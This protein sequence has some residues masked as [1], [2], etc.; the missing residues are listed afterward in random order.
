MY[1]ITLI[2]T[3]HSENGKCNDNELYKILEFINPEVIFD[4]LPSQYFDMF[5]SDS[6]EI[7]CANSILLNRKIPVEPLEVKSIK[8]YKQNYNVKVLPVDID[9]TSKL[10]KYQE[11]ILF[12]FSTFFKNQDY[13][14]LD[15]EKDV[16]IANEGFHYLNSE[17][18]LNFLER[19][20]ILEKNIIESDIEKERLYRIYKLFHSEQL[21]NRENEMIKNIYNFSKENHYNKAV[22]LLGAEH[23][24]SIMQK[25]T[26]YEKLSEIKLN[27][28]IYENNKTTNR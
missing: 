14:R 24:K 8:Q 26:E 1:N 3:I 16:L 4:E 23:K 20:E 18:F 11:E 7:Y 21:D 28:T 6:F 13:K 2:G 17:A 10:S 22:F 15:D 9:V 27:W 12:M 19:K 5:F 25:I